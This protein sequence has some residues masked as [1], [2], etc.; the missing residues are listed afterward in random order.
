MHA[1][2]RRFIGQNFTPGQSQVHFAGRLVPVYGQ[3][4]LPVLCINSAFTDTSNGA[5][6]HHAKVNQ[7]GDGTNFQ[8]VLRG[9]RSQFLPVSQLTCR[10][11]DVRNH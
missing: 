2:Q 5:F 3:P 6:I 1:H 4:K 9:K 8:I 10:R 7:V 11:E